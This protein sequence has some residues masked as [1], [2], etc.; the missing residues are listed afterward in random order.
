MKSCYR[1]SQ[2]DIAVTSDM[3][4]A[5]FLGVAFDTGGFRHPRRQRIR[6]DGGG[7]KGNRV[8]SARAILNSLF[9]TRGFKESKVLSAV[10]RKAK[11][12]EG[13]IVMSCM[14]QKDF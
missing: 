2:E 4:K 10:L 11:L 12:Y 13:Q 8:D 1:F 7:A 3:A 9:H 5:L 14:E 6:S